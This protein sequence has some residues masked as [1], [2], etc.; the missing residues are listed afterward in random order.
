MSNSKL[1][2]KSFKRIL[3]KHFSSLLEKS[4]T[5]MQKNKVLSSLILVGFRFNLS[6]EK[7]VVT[8]TVRK[9]F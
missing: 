3:L 5:Y 4:E 6:S 8:L 9:K 1:V 2:F 7:Y